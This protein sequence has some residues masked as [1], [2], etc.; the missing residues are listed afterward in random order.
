MRIFGNYKKPFM[1]I[2]ACMVL[3]V[4][5]S[6]DFLEVAPTGQL[7]ES[8]LAN[9]AG[10]EGLLIGAYATLNGEFGNRFEGPNRW[11]T[12]GIMGG[13]ANK[14]TDP[15]DYSSINPIQR[16][17]ISATNGDINNLWIGRYEGISRANYVLRLL[18]L[19]EDVLAEDA[20]RI[21]AEARMLRGHFYFELKIQ[22]NSVPYVDETTDYGLGI[23]EIPN[24]PNFWDKIEADF[25]YAYDNL[26]ETQSQVGR[27]NKW[28]AGAYLAKTYLFQEKWSQAKTVFDAVIANGVTSGGD[29]YALLDDFAEIYNAENDNHAEAVFAVQSANNTGSTAN[30][31]YFDDL[32]YPYNT[33]SDGPGN[34]CGFN[35]PSFSL[36]NSYRVGADGLP[37][38]D[39]SYNTEANEVKHDYGVESSDPFVED[40]GL[41]DPRL[42]HSVGR[43]GI[44][45][46]D[47]IDHPGKDWI[48]N[49]PYGGPYSPKKYSYYKSQE[50]SFTDGSSWTR[51]YATMNFTIIRYADVLLMAAEAE[52]E[53]GNLDKALEYVNLVRERAGKSEHWVK[54]ADGSDAANY[55]I[56]LYTA[57][58]FDT[59]EK[60]LERIYFE[61][62]LELSNEGHRLF[63]LARWGLASSELN[64]YLDWESKYL[65]TMFGGAN[66]TAG[67]EILPI[68]QSQIDIA[69]EGVLSQNPTY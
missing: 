26:P 17:E 61:R 51:G 16:Y 37:L 38:L 43:R 41:L 69:P 4:S 32:N 29:K 15:G 5:C 1:A 42:D 60:A 57:S 22:F 50:N 62:K 39:G 63:D 36:V 59:Q 56:S 6:E 64:A 2:L 54:D 66:F 47:W 53:L 21:A 48:R 13:D 45:Y 24:S 67:K 19:A 3:I 25:Q 10:I 8:T 44:P 52:A 33:G 20:T 9:K 46:L 23:E 30:A 58:D 68:P 11:V 34:C 18:P 27:V 65:T 12:G 28:A 7:A 40:D 35:Q 31:N 14:G 49:Q 55:M